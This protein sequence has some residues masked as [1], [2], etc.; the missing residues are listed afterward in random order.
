MSDDN[1]YRSSARE[2]PFDLAGRNRRYE[3][4]GG[5]LILLSIGLTLSI[6]RIGVELLTTHVTLVT[7][8]NLS[9]LTDPAS[10]HYM[11]WFGILFAFEVIGNVTLAFSAFCLLVL[12][13]R[14]SRRFP[15]LMIAF[16]AGYLAFVA[17]DYLL[18]TTLLTVDMQPDKQELSQM[19][20][21][22]AYSVIWTLY[23]LLSKRVKGTFVN[24]LSAGGTGD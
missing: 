2:E 3:T 12:M 10:D 24:S 23:L 17:V 16:F 11:P 18:G 20:S 19:G 5:W 13:F 22:V 1:P 21:G 8:G 4:I 7:D 14:R 15:V 9:L 6:V